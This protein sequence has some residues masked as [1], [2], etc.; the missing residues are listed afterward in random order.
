MHKFTGTAAVR[1]FRF[2]NECNNKRTGG[3]WTHLKTLEHMPRQNI[4]VLARKGQAGD[5][6]NQKHWNF[7]KKTNTKSFLKLLLK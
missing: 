1:Q 4:L 7:Y 2:V 5:R 6:Q 3:R